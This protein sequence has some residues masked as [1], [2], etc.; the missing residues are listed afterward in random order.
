MNNKDNNEIWEITK[1]SQKLTE[2][3]SQAFEAIKPFMETIS[4][5]NKVISSSMQKLAET[6]EKAF[7]S[8]EEKEKLIV[9]ADKYVEKGLVVPLDDSIEDFYSFKLTKRNI[10]N[11]YQQYSK[12]K[13]FNE[14]CNMF[15]SLKH[16]NKIYIKEAIACFKT[17][18]YLS[19]SMLLMSILDCEFLSVIKNKDGKKQNI[20]KGAIESEIKRLKSSKSFASIFFSEIIALKMLGKIYQYGGGFNDEPDMISRNYIMHGVSNRKITRN[21]CVM[22]FILCSYVD[23]IVAPHEIKWQFVD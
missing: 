11:I 20:T 18:K 19:C 7:L 15:G 5:I 3:F 13:R 21:D 8:D 2:S 22:L 4:E 12:P 17:R 14:L 9:L 16:V 6:I 1:M 23:Y 10:N